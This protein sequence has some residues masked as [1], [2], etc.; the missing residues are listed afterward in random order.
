MSVSRR[1]RR[2]PRHRRPTSR[3]DLRVLLYTLMYKILLEIM[4]V[5]ALVL[6]LGYAAYFLGYIGCMALH[7]LMSSYA[8]TFH[9]PRAEY[10]IVLIAHPP[11]P[12]SSPS[13]RRTCE[14]KRFRAQQLHECSICMEA[15]D[16]Q[17]ILVVQLLGCGHMFHLPCI[18]TWNQRYQ[19]NCPLCRQETGYIV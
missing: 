12:S 8:Q 4:M 17:H 14:S 16:G 5:I 13:R 9:R 18:R 19:Q 1:N 11:P 10:E 3:H 7:R 15:L 6:Y 2:R